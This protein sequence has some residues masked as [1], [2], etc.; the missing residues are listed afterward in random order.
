MTLAD[1]LVRL[2]RVRRC[3]GGFVACCPAHDDRNPSLS[4][5]EVDEGRLLLKCHA[6]CSHASIIAALGAELRRTEPRLA[7]A[8]P[9][10]VRSEAER[11]EFARRIWSESR[12]AT[13][14][15]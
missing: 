10:P 7:S 12:S 8:K 4:I 9:A 3:G 6:G 11:S 1:L 14:T 2:D 5:R 13:G 15:V